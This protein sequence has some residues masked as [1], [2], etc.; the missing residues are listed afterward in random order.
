[1]DAAL[2]ALATL[3]AEKG[4]GARHR[5]AIGSG[6]FVLIDESYN[7][8]PASMQAAI[9]LLKDAAVPDGGR[10]IAILGDMLEMGEFAGA[11]HAGLAAPLADAGI[12]DVWLA[13]SEMAHLRDALPEKRSRRISRDGRRA[14][15]I[16]AWLHHRRGC[17]DDQIVE[18][19]GLRQD[20]FGSS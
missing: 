18:G 10:R 16:C 9:S 15:G 6:S 2:A 5:L 14:E 4:R 17:G 7:A 13:G 12:A 8:N 19:H 11:V 3:Q 1:M 20:R